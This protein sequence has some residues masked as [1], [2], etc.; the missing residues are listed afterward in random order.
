MTRSF[1]GV[2]SLISTK[3]SVFNFYPK[4]LFKNK[5]LDTFVV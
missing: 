1:L 3:L 4:T 5:R 2:L